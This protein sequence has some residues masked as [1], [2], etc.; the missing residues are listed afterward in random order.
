MRVN[1]RLTTT[2]D[3][4]RRESSRS[5]DTLGPLNICSVGAGWLDR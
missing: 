4:W 1:T 5:E 3:N 2:L